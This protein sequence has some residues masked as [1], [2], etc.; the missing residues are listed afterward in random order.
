MSSLSSCVFCNIISNNTSTQLL[1]TDD[2][3]VAFQDINP[4]AFKLT[5]QAIKL[6]D[7]EQCVYRDFKDDL[8][9][10]LVKFVLMS[11][12]N[13]LPF[14]VIKGMLWYFGLPDD[15][16]QGGLGECFEVV[17]MGDGLKGLTVAK[18][19]KILSVIQK[20]ALRSGVYSGGE[21]E[22]IS[23]PLYPSKGLRLRTKIL[24]WLDGFQKLPYVSPY[25]ICPDLYPDSDVAEKRVVGLLH[26]L[27]SL[28][29]EHSV[30]RKRVLC[31]RKYL[32]LP[33]KVHKVF[34]R[35]PHVF[36]LS[37]RNNTCTAIL[38]D[39]YFDET[40]IEAHHLAEVRKKYINLVK[41]SKV[42]LK[43]RR[44]RNQS[45]W[46]GDLNSKMEFDG[47]DTLDG[48]HYLVIPVDHIATVKNLQRRTQDYSLV[49]HMLDVGQM[50]LTRDAP[51][52]THYR[53][54]FHQPPFNS[55]NHLHLH[56]L[57]FPFSPRWKRVKYSSLGPLGGFIE[58]RKLLER[59]KP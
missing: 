49:S 39:T 35:H 31:L 28:F 7:E 41:E 1:H 29:V 18:S 40:D 2:K 10:R 48:R 45:F 46:S 53:F 23:I 26:E 30:E 37:L 17:E 12:E 43:N 38:K 57:A 51:N 44:L 24:D 4:S 50:L 15:Y 33:Q 54:G 59:L 22:E 42:I 32:G 3:V 47:G 14:K 5:P 21:M 56:C 58:A 16:L 9:Q 55:V 34:E 27:L 20:N 36:Y 11:V 6:N 13:R 25:E 52:S 19:E 8:E